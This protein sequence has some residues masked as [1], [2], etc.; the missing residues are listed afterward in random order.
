M[1]MYLS[2]ILISF[3]ILVAS[4]GPSSRVSLASF[5]K[6]KDESDDEFFDAQ[7]R[8][9]SQCF[10]SAQNGLLGITRTWQDGKKKYEICF[11]SE[12]ILLCAKRLTKFRA[13]CPHTYTLHCIKPLLMVY[14]CDTVYLL[15]TTSYTTHTYM[16]L[17]ISTRNLIL[18]MLVIFQPLAF[19]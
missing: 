7:G 17:E 5:D 11:Q 2:E 10:S 14:G 19:L 18:P 3:F 6:I 1:L 9:V 4:P 13:L 8:N 12:H 15:Y 16:R